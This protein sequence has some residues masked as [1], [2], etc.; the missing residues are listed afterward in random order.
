MA[1][2]L[3]SLLLEQLG[4]I[5]VHELVQEVKLIKGVE[6]EVKSLTDTLVMI[7][8]VL[9]DA[10]EKQVKN[11]AV[12]IWLEQLKD[13]SYD[14]ED[15]LDEWITRTLI[16]KM[17][18]HE[19]NYAPIKEKARSHLFSIFCCFK[20][21]VLRHEIGVKI[22][23]LNKRLD[24]IARKKGMYK[25]TEIRSETESRIPTVSNVDVSD[26]YGRNVDKAVI[27]SKLLGETSHHDSK[28][29]VISI[30]G[31]GGFGKTTLA[32]LILKE[33]QVNN[34]F[35]K[36]I[37]VC[38]SDPFDHQMVAKQIIE[39]ATDKV[40][41]S[42]GW[43]ALHRKL[44]ESIQGK[45]FILV[46]D[47]IWSHNG[48]IWKQLKTSLD[49]GAIG[50][51]II[52][53]T[54]N[55]TI[56]HRM[57]STFIHRL[58]QLSDK[59]SLLMFK[60]IAF[61]NR[62]DDLQS[63][64]GIAVDIAKRCRGVPLSIRVLASLMR[65]KKTIQDWRN[66]QESNMWDVQVQDGEE[67]FLP[68]ISFSYYALPAKLKPCLVYCAILPKDSRIEKKKMVELW[69]AQGF[70]G[71][72]GRKDLE[73]EGGHYFDDLAMRS[74]FQDFKEDSKGNITSCMMHDLVHDFVQ[75]LSKGETCILNE[76]EELENVNVRHL[77]TFV[78]DKSSIYELKKLRTLRSGGYYR[79]KI[80]C[81]GLIHQLTS[82]RVLDLC[83]SDVEEFPSEVAR[84]LHLRYL[85]LSRTEL[86][87][88]PETICNLLNL[89]TLKLRYCEKLVKLPKGIGKLCS[90][91]H[92]MIEGTRSLT[93]LPAE[94]GKLC[95]LRTLDK[96]IIGGG[97]EIEGEGCNIRELGLLNNLQGKLQ[98]SNLGQVANANEAAEAKLEKKKNLQSLILS[99]RT[100]E[101]ATQQ[102][103]MAIYGDEGIL[104]GLIPHTNL[105]ELKVEFYKGT[106]LPDWIS[107]LSHLVKLELY[108]LV[109]LLQ[110]P[111]LGK[112]PFLEILA[113]HTLSVKH[114]G[115]EFYGLSSSCGGGGG[116]GRDSVQQQ[117]VFPKLKILKFSCM[118][119]WEEW[120]LPYQNDTNKIDFFPNLVELEISCCFELQGLPSGLAKLKSLKL[121][122]LCNL[123]RLKSFLSINEEDNG[124]F[125]KPPV[126]LFPALTSLQLT[127]VEWEEETIPDLSST[128]SITIM[129]CLSELKIH[130][131][132][133][134]KVIPLY[135]LSPALKDLEINFCPQLTRDMP[136]CLPPFLEKLKFLDCKFLDFMPDNLK[137]LTKLQTLEIID[138]PILAQR[139]KRTEEISYKIK[140]VESSQSDVR[141]HIG[142]RCDNCKM[143]PIVGKRYKCK[144]CYY[145]RVGG[146]DLC[147]ECYTTPSKHTDLVNQHH[148]QGH[149]F[150]LIANRGDNP[151]LLH[152]DDPSEDAKG[153][154][155]VT[156]SAEIE[157]QNK[158]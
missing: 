13:V 102:L 60:R 10:D 111:A 53:T 83:N 19:V 4:S 115:E 116:G 123:W 94:L 11:G 8:A 153:G 18:Q 17:L 142:V 85:D 68:S 87:E 38:V 96:F 34:H 109:S 98:I 146:F 75:F 121:L 52:I 3:V 59:D 32:Q 71:S 122:K 117:I 58:G 65:L 49:G 25:L 100:L 81:L 140:I 56:A 43:E 125:V 45:R 128:A 154:F 2:A 118:F 7:Q 55:E 84:L 114:I 86:E 113:L 35:D 61:W 80:T 77:T 44:S 119:V 67:G 82:L 36:Q 91:R 137:H 50:S 46:L 39:Q 78:F 21:V 107:L 157:E 110:L 147:E 112:L 106:K 88:L 150:E 23:E 54:R 135:M 16:S 6:N 132:E 129:P 1:E 152:P 31:T 158:G 73:I 134:L 99:F 97:D 155:V 57:G 47:D 93:Y 9:K 64:E 20:P 70:L 104:E 69:M 131:C 127:D 27:M 63:F 130:S 15:V 79:N 156:K 76:D 148:T 143:F 66:V 133:M 12:K 62:E 89:Q 51:R 108:F 30:V 126:V 151:V 101:A 103:P 42:V 120:D 37:W 139:F 41:D 40:I 14:A 29:P 26:I 48:E 105:E 138:C 28:V 141:V 145:V 24:E 74:F 144:D 90:L 124:E 136:S 72:D 33:K 92:L 95:C 5:V 22:M 149:T